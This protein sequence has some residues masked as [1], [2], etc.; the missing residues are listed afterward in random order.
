[1]F[2]GLYIEKSRK[3]VP[4]E[5][6]GIGIRIEDD[7]LITE[8]GAYNLCEECP[9]QPDDIESIMRSFRT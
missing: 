6:R 5:L 8:T 2:A 3:D 4:V 9:K 1:L 7:I